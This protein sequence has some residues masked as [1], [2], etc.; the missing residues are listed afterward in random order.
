[1]QEC[2]RTHS[3]QEQGGTQGHGRTGARQN[4]PRAHAN[5]RATT[6]LPGRPTTEHVSHAW[7]TKATLPVLVRPGSPKQRFRLRHPPKMEMLEAIV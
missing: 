5:T 7:W 1:M 6:Y 2:G 3:T 4:T